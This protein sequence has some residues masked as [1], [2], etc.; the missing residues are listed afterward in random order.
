MNPCFS[1][2]IRVET[3]RKRGYPKG[4][5]KK[6]IYLIRAGREY[7]KIGKT[8]GDPESR[9]A[10]LQVGCPM[11][12]RLVYTYQVNG[13]LDDH[14]RFLHKLFEAENVRGEW[15]YVRDK[16]KELMDGILSQTFDDVVN[17]IAHDHCV[18]HKGADKIDYSMRTIDHRLRD[19][20][21]IL[22]Y[23]YSYTDPKLSHKGSHGRAFVNY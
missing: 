4:D 2:N 23:K 11:E 17:K 15:F 9:L 12:L 13:D 21:L 5:P 6:T 22:N 18:E 3:K 20:H 8:T 1:R 19:E 16:V 7:V 10:S 14:E